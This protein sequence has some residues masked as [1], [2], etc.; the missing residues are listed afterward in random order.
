M[1]YNPLTSPDPKVWLDLDEQERIDL[2]RDYHEQSGIELP[3]LTLHAVIHT[4]VENQL[5]MNDLRVKETLDRL[6]TEGLDRHDALHAIGSILADQIFSATRDDKNKSRSL[7]ESYYK[8][9]R[10]LTAKKWKKAR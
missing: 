1:K 8:G 3:N 2:I 7:P 4:I 5:A 10:E 9:L 6:L